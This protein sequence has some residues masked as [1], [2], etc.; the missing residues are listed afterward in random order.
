MSDLCIIGGGH[1]AGKLINNLQQLGYNGN[2]SVYSEEG[3]LPY[4][5][6][7]LSKSF[8][9][10]EKSKEEFEINIDKKNVKFFS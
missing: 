8:L 5:R 10:G 4:E 6:P 7:P 3:Y 9:T 2:I 1:A